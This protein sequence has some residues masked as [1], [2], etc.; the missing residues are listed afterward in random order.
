MATDEV[1]FLSWYMSQ[2]A[3]FIDGGYLTKVLENFG[4][5]SLDY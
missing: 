1:A 5:P 3:I 2:C 4:R